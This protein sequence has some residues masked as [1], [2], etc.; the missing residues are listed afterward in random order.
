MYDDRKEDTQTQISAHAVGSD[1][2]HARDFGNVRPE[3]QHGDTRLLIKNG[4][5]G[6]LYACSDL[7]IP[8]SVRSFDNRAMDR[9]ETEQRG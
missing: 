5:V 1:D 7:S 8:G 2:Y 4:Q 9:D 3:M 6:K